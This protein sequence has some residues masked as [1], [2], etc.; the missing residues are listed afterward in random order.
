MPIASTTW[1]LN[2]KGEIV[3]H[4]GIGDDIVVSQLTQD[5]IPL[6]SSTGRVTVKLPTEVTL[7]PTYDVVVF[8]ATPGGIM[9]AVAAAKEGSTVAIFESS[10]RVGGAM[11]GG[12]SWTDVNQDW[13]GGMIVGLSNQFLR[14]LADEYQLP[15]QYFYRAV[16]NPEPKVILKK[17]KQWL[18]RYNIPVFLNND[19]ISVTKTG[20]VVN[21]IKFTTSGT[22]SAKAFIDSS[23]TGDLFAISGCSYSIGR[24]ANSTYGETLN[25]IVVPATIGQFVNPVDP[26]IIAGAPS[27]GLLYGVN[28]KIIGAAGTADA[29][30]MAFNY[31]LT[32][33][34]QAGKLAIPAPDNYVASQYEVLGRHAVANGSAWATADDVLLL[35]AV[36]TA[37]YVTN[38]YD[39]NHKGAFSV[40]FIDPQCTEYVTA[41][42]TRRKQIEYNMKQYILGL[43]QFLKT[44]SRIPAGVRTDVA[45]FGL[46]PDEFQENGGF[47]P[48]PYVREGRRIV[49]DFVM[50]EIDVTAF[51]SFTDGIAFTYYALDSHVCQRVVVGGAVKNEGT[52]P[53]NSVAGNRIPFRILLPKQT[54]CTN[55]LVTFGTSVSHVVFRTI[56]LEPIHMGLGHAAGVAAAMMA[57]SGVSSQLLD[58]NIVKAKQDRVN[59]VGATA[60]LSVDG[61]FSQGQMTTTLPGNWTVVAANPT[62]E[63]DYI[64]CGYAVSSTATAAKQFAPNLFITESYKVYARWHEK[65]VNATGVQRSLLTAVTVS[66]ASGTA[67]FTLDQNLAIVSN[68]A[69]DTGDWS[70]LGTYVFRKGAPSPD[71]VKFT[72]DGAGGSTV[73]SAVKWVPA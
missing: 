61:T 64:G 60:V 39:V 50:K 6:N 69:G 33:T 53:G 16:P 44:D 65:N 7:N 43:F 72:T 27:S 4:A 36:R 21:S 63:I 8:G 22:I 11:A 73:I 55:L 54:E 48:V 35:F 32:L 29:T 10:N 34:K 62:G 5:F 19:I 38:K 42:P 31:R 51:N 40:D 25:G 49:G 23:Y 15:W 45:T 70:Y 57:Q 18:Q 46:C 41:T 52:I 56:R 30:T 1:P 17:F 9:A 3:L 2:S 13:A 24:E 66:H 37:Q 28:P 59:V 47:T 58:V 71:T 14:E 26:Y 68:V 67:N 12:L 20:T